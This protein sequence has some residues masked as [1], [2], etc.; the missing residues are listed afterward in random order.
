M[1]AS[2]EWKG[3]DPMHFKQCWLLP[4]LGIELVELRVEAA[5][6]GSVNLVNSTVY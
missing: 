6:H 3:E 1:E 4:E 5:G 2:K